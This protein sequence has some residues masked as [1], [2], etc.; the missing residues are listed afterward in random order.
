M[1]IAVKAQFVFNR[2]AVR[3]TSG[4]IIEDKGSPADQ[5]SPTPATVVETTTTACR[6]R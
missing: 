4:F 3:V 6:S 2:M 5:K 1:P